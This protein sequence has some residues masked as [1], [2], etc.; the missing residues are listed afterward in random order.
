MVRTVG[1]TLEIKQL[2]TLI[3][4]FREFYMSKI[5]SET[6]LALKKKHFYRSANL[7]YVFKEAYAAGLV[8]KEAEKFKQFFSEF[9]KFDCLY[10]RD[11]KGKRV[12]DFWRFKALSFAW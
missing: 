4:Q 8:D 5:H 11:C 12:L 6:V 10:K 7:D 3:N 9:Q 1:R 2:N